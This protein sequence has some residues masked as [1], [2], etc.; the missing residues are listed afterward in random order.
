MAAHGA[1]G[2]ADEDAERHADR[3]AE[4]RARDQHGQ[5]EPEWNREEDRRVAVCVELRGRR[6]DERRAEG[7]IDNHRAATVALLRF[8]AAE[9]PLNLVLLTELLG[10]GGL[11]LRF[12]RL[13]VGVWWHGGQ[14][15]AATLLVSRDIDST[16]R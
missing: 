3:I 15:T 5:P 2:H 9:A 4:H 10:L 14:S 11:E 7:T 8:F 1:P 6:R 13:E 16:L 12:R